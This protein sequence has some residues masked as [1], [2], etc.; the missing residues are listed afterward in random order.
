VET[1]AFLDTLPAA[2]LRL[3][4]GSVFCAERPLT[5]E[6]FYE[7]VDEDTTADLV[8]GVIVMGSPASLQHEALF[9]F[10]AH[11]LREYVERRG[12]G[13]VLGSRLLVRIDLYNAREPDLMFIAA[14]REEIIREQE[15]AGA[16]DLIIEI[17][18]PRDRAREM[19]AKQAQ[20]EQLGVKEYWR[21]DLPKREATVWRLGPGGR[22]VR[23]QTE[24]GVL[25]SEVVAGFWVREEWLWREPGKYPAV[26]TVMEELL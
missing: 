7:L 19:I 16:P 23:A 15:I 6:E 8:Q 24:G 13:V 9:M 2:P 20:Y 11:L 5:V 12:L 22:Y 1:T 26:Q 3:P 18:S 14:G 10:L 21:I 25:R 4:E 17:I